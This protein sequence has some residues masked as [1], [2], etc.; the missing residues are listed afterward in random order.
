MSGF[1]VFQLAVAAGDTSLGSNLDTPFLSKV[2]ADTVC[3]A[4][5]QAQWLFVQF[6]LS[7]L[8]DK[9][10]SIPRAVTSASMI[11]GRMGYRIHS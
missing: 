11:P 3:Q 6:P 5:G 9:P 4:G 8:D 10:L 7:L 2:E 1:G